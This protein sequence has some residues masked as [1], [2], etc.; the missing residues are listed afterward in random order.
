MPAGTRKPTP[1]ILVGVQKRAMRHRSLGHESLEPR[2]CPAPV[3]TLQLPSTPIV[4]GDRATFTVRLSQPSST[5]QRVAVSAVSGSATLGR[6]FMFNNPTQLLFAPGQ[7]V[8]TFG[9]QTFT[10]SAVEA[11]ETLLIQA[12]PLTIPNAATVSAQA[13]IYELVQTTVTASDVQIT[14]GNSGTK[15]A[16]FTLRL[17]GSPILPV[18]VQYATQDGSA[19]AGS[20]YTAAS[21]QVFFNPGQTTKTVSVPI[22]GDQ[23]AEPDET[24]RLLLST[25]TR[26]CTIETPTV[27]GTIVNDEA[28]TPGFQITVVYVGN[29]SPAQQAAFAAAAA[30]W[31]Q[32]ISG[33]LPGVTLGNGTFIDDLQIQASIVT[34][35]GV[36]GVLGQAG[37]DAFRGGT[38]G[39]A[40]GAGLPY[41]G[42]MEFDTADVTAMETG[43]TL[44]GVIM[45]E[46]GHVLGLGTLWSS[47]NL[48]SG[49][50][51]ANPVYV[52]ANAV[53]E[54]NAI[55]GVTGSSVPV[56][57]TG[58]PGTRDVHWRES[59]MQTELMTGYASPAGVAMPL[60]RITVGSLADLGY[61]VNYG[62]ADVY[63]RPLVTPG[64][65]GG[66]IGMVLPLNTP[67]RPSPT[68]V[69]TG[70]GSTPSRPGEPR[71]GGGIPTAFPPQPTGPRTQSASPRTPS[72]PRT[73]SSAPRITAASGA[74]SQAWGSLGAGR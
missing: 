69:P 38:P 70:S 11:P 16:T 63:N 45:H 44:Q 51:G 56:E 59:T 37:P 2:D 41:T 61:T 19:T 6:D 52:G 64:P 9:V 68:L 46:M 21:G 71:P 10:D 29:V 47:L 28:D 60:S 31:S 1:R 36:G 53:R 43:G 17:A 30:R 7:T 12:T 35:D 58:G 72:G 40:G 34:I 26:G 3:V 65:A 33:D 39:G 24:F 66:G 48:V 15:N 5:P 50:G 54:Y 55:F 74:Q 22:L 13:T 67:T 25:S 32:V 42:V 57:N 4:E 62:A 73:F 14:E 27:T 8:K 23:I 20:D 18:F 49:A